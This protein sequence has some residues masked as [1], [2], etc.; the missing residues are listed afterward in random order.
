MLKILSIPLSII[1][2]IYLL[3]MLLVFQPIQYITLRL[4]GYEA[5]K[6]SVDLLNFLLL[7]VLYLLFST[8][9]FNFK[10][11]L[12]Q[13]KPLIIVANH[14]GVFDIMSIG[15]AMRKFHPKYVSKIE[16][17]KNIPSV[18]FNLKHGGSVTIDR[19]NPRQALPE[20]KRMSE[21]IQQNNRSAVIFPEGTRSRNGEPKRFSINGLK[22]LCKYA[23]DALV[24]PITINNS[25]KIY[26]Y[27]V[28]PFGLGNKL[29]LI[30]HE[31][32]A[33]ADYEFE[34]LFEKTEKVIVENIRN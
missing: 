23:P 14:Q 11:E 9:K 31:A 29:E 32:L 27:G 16:L 15:W 26:R 13:N 10:S 20:L 3:L 30:V 7:Q 6:R 4:F 8:Y 24:V 2:Y 17:A 28:F 22:V 34:E 12:P 33:V 1:A 25:W 18:S 21:Y 19:K 5:H